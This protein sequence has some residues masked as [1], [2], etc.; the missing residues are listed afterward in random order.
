MK[1]FSYLLSTAAAGLCLSTTSMAD[2]HG[3]PSMKNMTC[4]SGFH[5]GLHGGYGVQ[6]T[7]HRVTNDNNG[8]QRGTRIGNG[9][10]VFGASLG[11]THV[12]QS[13]F[14]LGL[15]A[16]IDHSSI[17]GK[18]QQTVEGRT[19]ATLK[20]KQKRFYGVYARMGYR[21]GNVA[22][23]VKLGYINSKFDSET[24]D[25]TSGAGNGVLGVG[26]KSK[27]LS[28][29]QTGLGADIALNDRFTLGMDY[30]YARYERFSFNGIADNG[31][32]VSTTAV[33]PETHMFMVNVK[34]KIY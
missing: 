31:V 18:S 11:Y 24:I 12:F 14:L 22:P 8:T 6:S 23:Y 2:M 16:H 28:G 27:N 9:G 29:F 19:E 13:N 15:T 20:D 1:K 25:S 5:L 34:F 10:G 7:D 3:G 21:Y 33:R 32:K 17:E 4:F 30:T 26:K